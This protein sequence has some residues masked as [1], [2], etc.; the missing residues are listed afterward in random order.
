MY[1]AE[2]CDARAMRPDGSFSQQAYSE[3]I[4]SERENRNDANAQRTQREV[5]AGLLPRVELTE[6]ENVVY[7]L[8]GDNAAVVQVIAG[9]VKDDTGESNNM[10]E[11]DV[12]AVL[13]AGQLPDGSPLTPELRRALEYVKSNFHD[14][15]D[16]SSWNMF[17]TG[18][19][20]ADEITEWARDEHETTL[21]EAVQKKEEQRAYEEQ[22]N[23]KNSENERDGEQ[24]DESGEGDHNSAEKAKSA[25]DNDAEKSGSKKD[26]VAEA[27]DILENPKASPEDKLKAIE[28]L[29]AAGKEEIVLLD[30]GKPVRC[31]IAI[32][33]VAP[34]SD[35]NYVHLFAEDENGKER[36]V[37]RAIERE[38]QYYRQVDAHGRPLNYIGDVWS[39]RESSIS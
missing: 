4:E 10:T 19:L 18:D 24:D 6:E 12:D 31:R 27:M 21:D 7:E 35:R 8:T 15:T 20:T 39:G 28:A 5:D 3:C 29:H 1:R 33:P 11:E 37:L 13:A 26:E 36:I 22:K 23:Q 32:A 30:H 17:D 14:M 2:A 9:A 16:E 25:K 38:G 34:G